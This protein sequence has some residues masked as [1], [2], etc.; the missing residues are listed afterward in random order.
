[1]DIVITGSSGFVGS[2]LTRFLL[3][4][5]H[6][7]TG[8]DAQPDKRCADRP[9]FHFIQAD[10][11]VS[12]D[13]QNALKK[14]DVVINLAGVNIF[15]RWTRHYKQLIYDSRILT[16]KHLAEALSVSSNTLLISTSAVGFY[17]DRKDDVLDETASAGDDFLAR[18]C[19]DWEKEAVKARSKSARVVITR[20]AVVLGKNG[21]ALA[22][23]VPA[24]KM[25]VGG[26]LGDGMQWFSWVHMDDLIKAMTYIMDH[27]KIEGPVNCCAP[28]PVR[29][30]D[31][32][33][34]LARRLNRPAFFRMPAWMMRLAAGELGDL[35]L[36]SQ[37]AHPAKLLS[38][39]FEFKY[40]DVDRALAVSV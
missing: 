12:G 2:H 20:F 37:R 10:T 30:T 31:F 35:A 29:N 16:T 9:L 38:A 22:K 32:S 15:R 26:P 25:F 33:K 6:T 18:V 28:H 11:T 17:G 24:Y 34:A 8:I 39:G 27:P 13:W 7:V 19:V 4:A 21:G 5:G 14:K 3:D 36:F 1:M 23:M 40:P